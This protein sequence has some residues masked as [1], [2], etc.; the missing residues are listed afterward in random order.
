MGDI[1]IA[2]SSIEIVKVKAKKLMPKLRTLLKEIRNLGKLEYDSLSISEKTDL[3]LLEDLSSEVDELHCNLQY[4]IAEKDEPYNLKKGKYGR[5]M[6]DDQYL[7][8]RFPFDILVPD[9]QSRDPENKVW[10]KVYVTED[11][12]GNLSILERPEIQLVGL[13]A[14]HRLTW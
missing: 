2:D 7:D 4:I 3:Q 13:T 5:Y 10:I 6:L 14:R 11:R 12:K 8:S 1:K 9:E